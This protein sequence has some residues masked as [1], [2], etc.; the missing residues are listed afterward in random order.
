MQ[1]LHP[2][3]GSEDTRLQSPALIS[4]PQTLPHARLQRSYF[5]PRMKPSAAAQSYS[6]KAWKRRV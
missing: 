4:R 6:R 3:P 1:P 5:R 2:H